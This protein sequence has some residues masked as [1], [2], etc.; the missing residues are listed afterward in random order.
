MSSKSRFDEHEGLAAFER[1]LQADAQRLREE[2]GQLDLTNLSDEQRKL[3][4]RL[5]AVG[6]GL[7][8]GALG[9]YLGK[10]AADGIS[11]SDLPRALEQLETLPREI[12]ERIRA[13]WTGTTTR[14]RRIVIPED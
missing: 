12:V 13:G 10:R 1:Q 2:I 5:L 8:A 4:L 6:A 9:L 11:Q 3:L 14:S 7:G